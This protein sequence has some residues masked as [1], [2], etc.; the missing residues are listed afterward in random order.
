MGCLVAAR[1]A[2]DKKAA[3]KSFMPDFSE[4]QTAEEQRAAMMA[5]FAGS[6]AK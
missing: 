4:P 6:E 2:G 3:L 5:A 1:I